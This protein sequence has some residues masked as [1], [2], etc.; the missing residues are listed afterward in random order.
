[1]SVDRE[2]GV[3][4]LLPHRKSRDFAVLDQVQSYWS[5]LLRDGAIPLR[6]EIDPRRIEDALEYAFIAE[7]VT[8]RLAKLRVAGA[9][10][11]DLAGMAVS[12]MPLGCM[13]TQSARPHLAEAT[14]P[15]FAKPAVIRLDMRSP[16][17]TAREPIEAKMLLLPL[18]SDL[19]DV[20]RA[21]G[22][23]ATRGRIGR[24]PRRFE[25]TQITVSPIETAPVTPERPVRPAPPRPQAPSGTPHLRLV[26]SND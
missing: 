14:Q 17:G 15:L 24:T 23:L 18:R 5:S 26:V 11:S 20:T 6:S 3:I 25:I 9:H 22:C 4:S 12:G 7:R 13:F 1:M 19:G 2:T 16:T 8:E 21:L 10:L